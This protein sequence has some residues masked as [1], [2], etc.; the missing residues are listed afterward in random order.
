MYVVRRTRLSRAEPNSF[1]INCSC[2]ARA[3]YVNTHTLGR[4]LKR[5]RRSRRRIGSDKLGAF[6][7]AG[8]QL[9]VGLADTL[10]TKHSGLLGFTW[11]YCHFIAAVCLVAIKCSAVARQRAYIGDSQ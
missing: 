11:K 10:H 3:S 1:N 8:C 9:V 4:K 5:R 7:A 2:R 6:A